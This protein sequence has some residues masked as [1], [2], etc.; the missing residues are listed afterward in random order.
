MNGRLSIKRAIG[1]SFVIGSDANPAAVTVTVVRIQ[2]GHVELQ[3]V[4]PI[5]VK[6]K[7]SELLNR[8]ADALAHLSRAPRGRA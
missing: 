1:E 8:P 7:R 4:A 6:V 5:E 3:V 2:G